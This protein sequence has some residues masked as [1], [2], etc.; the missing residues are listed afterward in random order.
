LTALNECALQVPVANR[1]RECLGR[2]SHGECDVPVERAQHAL[3]IAV[4]RLEL[5]QLLQLAQAQ[6]VEPAA[7]L[8]DGQLRVVPDGEHAVFA[9]GA[10]AGAMG[11]GRHADLGRRA[12]DDRRARSAPRREN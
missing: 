9:W 12:I 3:A 1:K 10:S 4:L 5:P 2:P 8:R 6:A 11:G 7:D